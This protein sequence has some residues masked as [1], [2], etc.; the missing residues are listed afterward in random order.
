MSSIGITFDTNKNFLWGQVKDLVASHEPEV[1]IRNKARDQIKNLMEEILDY[2]FKELIKA[3]WHEIT[4][5]RKDRRNGYRI[6]SLNTSMGYIER[7]NVPR[8]RKGGYE[9]KLFKRYQQRSKEFDNMVLYGVLCGMSNRRI[10]EYFTR[11]F[12]SKLSE[13]TISN[14]M[15]KL[16]EELKEF[17]QFPIAW[18]YPYLIVDG[19]AVHILYG[20]VMEE[21]VVICAYGLDKDLKGDLLAFM[22]CDSENELSYQA[23]FNDLYRRG[24]N[25]VDLI[26]H[27]GAKGIMP[28]AQ[29]VYPYAQ[30]QRCIFH[31][32]MNLIH[33][34]QRFKNKKLMLKESQAIFEAKTKK[35]ALALIQVFKH[36]WFKKEPKAIKNFLKDIELTLTY[37]SFTLAHRSAITTTNYLERYFEEI[38]RRIKLIGCF[39]NQKSCERFIYGLSK[40]IYK[41]LREIVHVN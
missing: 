21:K 34:I 24:L 12:D 33:N 31:K 32:Q 26:I 19:L 22:V 18:E 15:Q 1:A 30:H 41:D 36:K 29:M 28:A 11:F 3:D 35:E 5:G 14:I 13:S 16:D 20:N 4:P 25:S 7:I 10:T 27:D 23:L 6:R 17:R 37:F 39:R 8:G 2:D 9:F 38:R 40:I